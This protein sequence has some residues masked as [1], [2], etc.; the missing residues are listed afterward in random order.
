[1]GI[2]P[3]QFLPE[4]NA[5]S[6]ELSGKEKFTI[7]MPDSLSPRQQLT[8]EVWNQQHRCLKNTVP[9]VIPSEEI[10]TPDMFL[11][12][13]EG[14]SFPVTAM[15][16]NEI[17]VII[18]QN[19]GHLRYV[20]R[21]FL[22][23][24]NPLLPAAVETHEQQPPHQDLCLFSKAGKRKEKKLTW[25]YEP[26]VPPGRL[27]HLDCIIIIIIVI[28]FQSRDDERTRSGTSFCCFPKDTA[29]ILQ[30][31]R[32]DEMNSVGFWAFH[33]NTVLPRKANTVL[34]TKARWISFG[35]SMFFPNIG[36]KKCH[37]VNCKIFTKLI[38]SPTFSFC[39]QT[40][41]CHLKFCQYF[42]N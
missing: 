40:I 10:V 6:L 23:K 39:S 26:D 28:A 22:W 8:V 1:M 15:F 30:I 41:L 24:K 35:C 20:A 25:A 14:K 9:G 37:F 3:L 19:G 38:V 12:T 2:I 4:Q 21:T 13:S 7:T 18:F 17:D 32:Q 27:W 42:F 16:D 34:G 5:D 11:Q 36:K 33:S 29:F 31:P